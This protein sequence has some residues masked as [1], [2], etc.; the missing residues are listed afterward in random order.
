MSFHKFYCYGRGGF[1][2]GLPLNGQFHRGKVVV[3][4]TEGLPSTGVP[5]IDHVPAL[6]VAEPCQYQVTASNGTAIPP[7]GSNIIV[8]IKWSFTEASV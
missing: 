5:T 4:E 3:G 7:G 2:V 8:I 6:F 1:Q